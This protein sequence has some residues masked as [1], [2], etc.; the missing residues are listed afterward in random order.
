MILVPNGNH[1][2]VFEPENLKLA[3]ILRTQPHGVN[4]RSY[5]A[6]LA[7]HS[8]NAMTVRTD[9]AHS[10]TLRLFLFTSTRNHARIVSIDTSQA[11]ALAGAHGV[12]TGMDFPDVY[13]GSGTT[14]DL[15]IMAR[16]EVFYVGEP[17][18]AVAADGEM[19]DSSGFG[20]GPSGT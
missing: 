11:L 17:V 6:W 8:Q 16:D 7:L 2:S 14:R 5:L 10:R 18:A 1:T 15:R 12:I 19:T 3:S 13:F 9:S 4:G 20:T